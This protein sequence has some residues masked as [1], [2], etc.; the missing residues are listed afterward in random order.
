MSKILKILSLLTI[1]SVTLLSCSKETSAVK[2]EENT[3]F[4]KDKKIAIV[5]FSVSNNTKKFAET[6]QKLTGG[7][8]IRLEPVVDYNSN[9]KEIKIL[10][11]KT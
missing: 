8:L 3:A 11:C 2:P 6:I 4:F 9:P 5:Y 1:L 7:D 10:L